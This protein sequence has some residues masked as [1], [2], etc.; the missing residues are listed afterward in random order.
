MAP[1]ARASSDLATRKKVYEKIA[2]KFLSSGWMIYVYHPALPDRPHRAAGGL[3]ALSGRPDPRH[4]REA[5]ITDWTAWHGVCDAASFG[6]QL[7]AG[8]RDGLLA[9][10]SRLL[11]CLPGSGS[12]FAQGNLR[13]GLGD[14]PDVLDPSLSRTYTARIVFATLCDKLFDIDEKAN[15]VPQ[16]AT[17]PRDL[18]RR[19]DRHHQAATGREVPRRRGLRR[20]GRQVQPRP[21]SQHE[22]LVPQARARS[23]DSVEVVDPADH[24]AQPQGALLAAAGPAHRPRRHDGLAQGGRGQRATSSA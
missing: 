6:G 9:A 23:V 3:Q 1:E 15:I 11:L 4:G 24:Q 14:D 20:G 18:G 17:R 19:Q 8:S 2:A 7:G 13:I 22:G 12:A 21:P 16:L 5:E 10:S